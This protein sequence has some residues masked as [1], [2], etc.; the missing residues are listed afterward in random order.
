MGNQTSALDAVGRA[1]WH[2]L[3]AEADDGADLLGWHFLDEQLDQDGR[4]LL[5]TGAAGTK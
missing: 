5:H 1:T 3:A 4:V 2:C